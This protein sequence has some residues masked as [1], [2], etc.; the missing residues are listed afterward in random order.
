MC[1]CIIIMWGTMQYVLNGSG[2]CQC[3]QRRKQ[4]LFLGGVTE[5]LIEE[6]KLNLN[7]KFE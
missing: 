7:L 1:S 2:K 4:L 5:N 3:A 6:V